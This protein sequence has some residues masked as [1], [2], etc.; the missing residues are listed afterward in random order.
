MGPAQLVGGMLCQR[1]GGK[2]TFTLSN[3][4]MAVFCLMIPFGAEFGIKVVIML[5]VLQGAVGVSND[6]DAQ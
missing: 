3:L 2:I 4:L 6:I 1:Y 5:R